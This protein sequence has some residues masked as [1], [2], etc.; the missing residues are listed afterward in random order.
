MASSSSQHVF[1]PVITHLLVKIY[2]GCPRKFLWSYLPPTF[3]MWTHFL[4][5]CQPHNLHGT[6]TGNT[7]CL[8]YFQETDI[9]SV[10]PS[11][12]LMQHVK[13]IFQLISNIPHHPIFK[14]CSLVNIF[15]A[16][17]SDSLHNSFQLE[18]QCTTKKTKEQLQLNKTIM[19]KPWQNPYSSFQISC[20]YNVVKET[21]LFF[22]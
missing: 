22:S 15:L 2:F 17:F 13:R 5:A 12:Q 1:S 3:Y 14:K 20:L 21:F 4:L 18:A 11:M 6:S 7:L 16:L 19:I 8:V 10:I 9:I